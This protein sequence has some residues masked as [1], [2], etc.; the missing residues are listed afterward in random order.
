M[1]TSWWFTNSV[2]VA[3][4][5]SLVLYD[6]PLREDEQFKSQSLCVAWHDGLK[7]AF[8]LDFPVLC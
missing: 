7:K 3:A 8:Q 1:R 5:G 6:I 4:L 2:V